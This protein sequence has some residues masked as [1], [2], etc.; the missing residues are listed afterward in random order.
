[1][2][3]RKEE[4]NVMMNELIDRVEYAKLE[5]EDRINE[6]AKIDESIEH[7]FECINE[8]Q[9]NYDEL[10]RLEKDYQAKRAEL[11]SKVSQARNIFARRKT[12]DSKR[13]KL[14]ALSYEISDAMNKIRAKERRS[15]SDEQ[16][17]KE[18]QDRLE[19]IFK[20]LQ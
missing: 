3:N 8:L 18:L 17:L 6:M 10:D 14:I 1:M 20:K 9:S 7:L 13:E 19:E 2:K 5:S 4:L 12:E 11:Q 16:T 15:E